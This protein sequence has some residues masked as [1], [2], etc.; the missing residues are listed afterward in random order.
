MAWRY[1]A[2]KL[3][4]PGFSESGKTLRAKMEHAR[5]PTDAINAAIEHR[6]HYRQEV[7]TPKGIP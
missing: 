3:E 4:H 6:R 7:L 2:G 1:A 5:I